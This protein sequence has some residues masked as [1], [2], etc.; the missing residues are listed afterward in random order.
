MAA[1]IKASTFRRSCT[2]RIG[3][4][5]VVIGQGER[6]DAIRVRGINR[7][8]HIGGVQ[9]A[10][11]DARHVGGL[12]DGPVDGPVMGQAGRSDVSGSRCLVS[13]R[14]KVGNRLIVL[15]ILHDLLFVERHSG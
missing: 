13:M 6:V 15:H 12:D 1:L 4:I 10:G 14:K 8:G 3:A 11:D 2:I 9:T 5:I 7:L